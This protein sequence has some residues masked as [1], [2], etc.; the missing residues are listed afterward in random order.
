MYYI[1]HLPLKLSLILW[2]SIIYYLAPRDST[3]EMD[4]L[5]VFLVFLF[6][7]RILTVRAAEYPARTRA[8]SMTGMLF[9]RRLAIVDASCVSGA[10][11]CYDDQPGCCDTGQA[12]TFDASHRPICQGSCNGLL[13][14]SGDMAGLCCEI[15]LTCNNQATLCEPNSLTMTSMILTGPSAVNTS[16]V[17]GTA[18][19]TTASSPA[20]LPAAFTSAAASIPWY[21]SG[22]DIDMSVSQDAQSSAAA[23]SAAA[24]STLPAAE[25]FPIPLDAVLIPI[26]YHRL[27]NPS[28]QD[29]A[30][31]TRPC[32]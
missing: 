27:H 25:V 19:A 13:N 3:Q 11:R 24:P 6:S 29:L 17:V 5:R 12:C 15:G 28:N 23:T 9:F 1:F 16:T 7:F 31:L 26:A 22:T 18:I 20:A 14:C 10:T 32:L 30:S 4:I 21:I 2:K 8:P